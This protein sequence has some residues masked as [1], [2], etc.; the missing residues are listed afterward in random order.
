[1]EIYLFRHGQA[2]PA[3]ASE[4]DSDRHLTP[5]G[6]AEVRRIAQ[7]IAAM[8]VEP[9]MILSSPYT[10]A[11][12]TARIAAEVLGYD[13]GIL[14]TASL[15]PDSAPSG[16]W[17]EIRL[18]PEA[19]SLLLVGHEPLLSTALAWM[20]GVPAVAPFATAALARVDV[21]GAAGPV[22]H[23]TMRFLMSPRDA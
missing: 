8:G 13:G 19:E 10:R 1:M 22:P 16:V 11:E 23:A 14:P 7:R 17:T 3:S 2:E 4:R 20:L 18:F 15:T 9:S 12:E 5:A 21:P 6:Q